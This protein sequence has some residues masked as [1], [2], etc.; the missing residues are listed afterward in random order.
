MTMGIGC[1]SIKNEAIFS[2]GGDT[3]YVRMGVITRITP[4]G[5][6][7]LNPPRW[8]LQ[9]DNLRE[10]TIC[11]WGVPLPQQGQILYI[12]PW[13]KTLQKHG[14][15]FVKMYKLEEGDS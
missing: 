3:T 12:W 1:T 9:L 15:Y 4:A 6:S 11:D 8:I 10:I 2:I 7:F 13:G 5:Q 14:G